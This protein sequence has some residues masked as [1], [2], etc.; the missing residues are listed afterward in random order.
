MFVAEE[1][2]ALVPS[3]TTQ[4]TTGTAPFAAPLATT[5]PASTVSLAAWTMPLRTLLP[6]SLLMASLKA[7]ATSGGED[8]M[9]SSLRSALR[10]EGRGV[11][12]GGLGTKGG[13]KTY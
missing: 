8:S 9:T 11:D 5:T 12:E 4:V 2:M 6:V 7:L 3:L 1:M 13:R 10:R